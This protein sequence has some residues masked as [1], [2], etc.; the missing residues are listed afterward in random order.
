M[1]GKDAKHHPEE[2]PEEA[3]ER[4][5]AAE[6][7]EKQIPCDRERFMAELMELAQQPRSITSIPI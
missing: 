4:L 7:A 6:F 3:F 5:M 2:T 1:E